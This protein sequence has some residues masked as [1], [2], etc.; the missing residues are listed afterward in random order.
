MQFKTIPQPLISIPAPTHNTFLKPKSSIQDSQYEMLHISVIQTL[1]LS[2]KT[3][4]ECVT[5][6]RYS[7]LQY[8]I[9]A[10][11]AV[12]EEICSGPVTPW[13]RIDDDVVV[14]SRADDLSDH[15]SD[16]LVKG[17]KSDRDRNQTVTRTINKLSL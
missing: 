6:S 10:V 16:R 17:P 12:Q 14:R 9:F 1:S 15:G 4:Y 5:L 2:S 3:D 11:G 7:R 13:D 8:K